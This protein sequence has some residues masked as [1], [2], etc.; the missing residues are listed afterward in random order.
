MMVEAL[1]IAEIVIVMSDASDTI[2]E[3][4]LEF[5]DADAVS[6]PVDPRLVATLKTQARVQ[7]TRVA[8]RLQTPH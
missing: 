1:T 3:R 5:F 2:L 8:Q 4:A 7:T 6:G